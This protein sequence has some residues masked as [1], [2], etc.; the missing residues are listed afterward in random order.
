[1]SNEGGRRMALLRVGGFD[2]CGMG[3]NVASVV[4]GADVV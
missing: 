2:Y 4:G 1:M 3:G